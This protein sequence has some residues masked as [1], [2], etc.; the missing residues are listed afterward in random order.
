VAVVNQTFVGDY[1][2][3]ENPIGRHI[4]VGPAA[5]DIV[6][7]V[8]VAADAKYTELRGLTPATIYFPAFQRIDGTAN[9]AVRIAVPRG[10]SSAATA[11][12][13]A[14]IRTAVR[15]ID[16]ALPVLN[17]RT[18]E[19]QIGRLHAQ[20]LLFARLSGVFG[21]VALALAS[22]GL[23]GLLS[24]AV[25]RRTGEIG[26]R[27]A[28]GAQPMAVLGMIMR[29]SLVLV[30]CGILLG[31]AG[32]Y[33]ASRIVR[34]MLFG[35]TPGDPLTYGAVALMLSAIAAIASALPARRASRIDPIVALRQ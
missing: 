31:A 12:V 8:G 15:D 35:L 28:L 17:L 27:M 19:E 23:Y 30:C 7:I 2:N 16:P 22:V 10:S 4:A 21:V 6:E 25:L 1:L 3:G 29:E 5:A 24:H 34:S 11:A 26:L 33:A 32:A 20:E 13:F 14:A 18:Q 9:Y